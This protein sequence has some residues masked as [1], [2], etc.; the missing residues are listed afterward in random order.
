MTLYRTTGFS[1]ETN[2]TYVIAGGLGGLGRS[3]ARWMAA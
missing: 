3:T 2:A 1:L